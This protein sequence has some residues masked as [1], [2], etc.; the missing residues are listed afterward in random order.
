MNDIFY[1]VS[2]LVLGFLIGGLVFRDTGVNLTE[3]QSAVLY[4]CI[5]K[6]QTQLYACVQEA[7]DSK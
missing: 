6:S 3:R 5:E 1:V 4:Q 7:K 2:T